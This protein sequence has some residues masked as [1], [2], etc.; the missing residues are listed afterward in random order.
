VSIGIAP[1]R[2]RNRPCARGADTMVPAGEPP[3]SRAPQ[4]TRAPL[5]SGWGSRATSASPADSNEQPLWQQMVAVVAAAAG[6]A[7]WVSTV[8]S[9]IVALRL[10][11]AHL[12]VEP[13]VALMSAEHRFAIGAG[14]FAAPL[15]AG[16]VGFLVDWAFAGS[17]EKVPH[18]YRQI[19]ATATTA[20]GFWGVARLLRLPVDQALIQ[21]AAVVAGV[22]FTFQVLKREPERRHRFDERVGVFIAVLVAAGTGALVYERRTDEMTFAA[23]T[24]TLKDGEPVQGGYLTST[25]FAVVLVRQ[26]KGCTVVEA[27]PRTLIARIRVGPGSVSGRSRP[28]RPAV[29]PLE[30]QR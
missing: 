21:G 2:T 15:L 5:F 10:E 14:F 28:C 17:D 7:A 16:F 12:P 3:E 27:V 1:Q 24:I 13:V 22:V 11:H 20:A 18:G 23:A 26:D 30:P 19:L 9:G 25:D 6:G 8:G 4:L 29:R